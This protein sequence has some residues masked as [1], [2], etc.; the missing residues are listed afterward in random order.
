MGLV[1]GGC[2]WHLLVLEGELPLPLL[3]LDVLVGHLCA[4]EEERLLL[5]AGELERGEF[6]EGEEFGELLPL[7]VVQDGLDVLLDLLEGTVAQ[8][9][10][11]DLLD[12]GGGG[13]LLDGLGLLLAG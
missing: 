5:L 12:L 13:Q 6:L 10:G 2:D 4:V 3:V 8:P 1:L 9:D 7:L 11:R